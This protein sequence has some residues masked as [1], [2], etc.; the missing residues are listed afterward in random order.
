MFEASEI[1]TF[2]GGDFS[3]FNKIETAPQLVA[4]L[5]KWVDE[6]KGWGDAKIGE[7]AIVKDKIQVTLKE[8][9]VQ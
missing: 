4:E 7:V 1:K 6:V 3:F 5:Q 2:M 9:I 8:G